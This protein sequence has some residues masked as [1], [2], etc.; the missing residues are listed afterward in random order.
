MDA[1]FVCFGAEISGDISAILS[2]IGCNVAKFLPS[3]AFDASG[4]ILSSRETSER[5][6]DKS[7]VKSIND[8]TFP[9]CLL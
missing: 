9:I 5:N 3:F 8:I 4:V 7:D 6:L 1:K 2:V